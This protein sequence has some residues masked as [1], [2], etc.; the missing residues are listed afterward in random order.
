MISYKVRPRPMSDILSDIKRKR[1]VISPHFQRNFVWRATHKVDFIDTILRGLPFPQIFL[2]KGDVNIDMMAVNSCVVD[3]QQRLNAILSFVRGDFAVDGRYYSELSNP[4]KEQF[5]RYEVPV[6]ELDMKHD[7]PAV[8][9]IF[10]RLN[11]TFYALSAIEKTATEYA[12]SEFMLVAKLAANDLHRVRA[13]PDTGFLPGEEDDDEISLD[14]NSNESP[15]IP[16]EFYGWATQKSVKE[17][18]NYL[19]RSGVFSGYELARKVQLMFV[20]N[21]FATYHKGFYPRN[22]AVKEFLDLY[23]DGYPEKDKVIASIEQACDTLNRIGLKQGSYWLNKANAFTLVVFLMKNDDR[24]FDTE[25]M[26]I[27]LK[28]FATDI[29]AE[30]QLAAKEAVNNKR[31]RNL[32]DRYITDLLIPT[33]VVSDPSKVS[34][35]SFDKYADYD[36]YRP[37]II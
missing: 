25:Q 30:Y 11:R 35:L 34:N 15:L 8:I 2:A 18:H 9:D 33:S 4:E 20:L 17:T 3:G 26:R 19:L 37:E 23:V 13:Q 31:E 10:K 7:D 32:R 28:Q 24:T 5:I 21:I 1:L 16:N 29:P 14:N 12:A 36:L 22:E 6:I 27:I